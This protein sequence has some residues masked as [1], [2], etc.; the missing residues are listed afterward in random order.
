MKCI[1]CGKEIDTRQAHNAAPMKEGYCCEDCNA[2]VVLPFR[3]FLSTC[4]RKDTA[5]WV[6]PDRFELVK[7]Q[8]EYFTLKE[9]QQAVDGYIELVPAPFDAYLAIANEDGILIGLP[10]NTLFEQA[11]GYKLVGNV[12]IVPCRIFEAPEEDED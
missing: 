3:V 7:P 8:G 4:E 6:K 1:F 12:L 10:L 9:L 11:F 2:K 5:L